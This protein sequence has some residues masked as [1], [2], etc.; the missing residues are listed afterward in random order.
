MKAERP[1]AL[2]G[3]VL[4]HVALSYIS[5]AGVRPSFTMQSK[6]IP[7]PVREDIRVYHLYFKG[8][9]IVSAGF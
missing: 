9:N 4:S 3:W 1:P 6:G 7:G 8:H 2:P 5:M